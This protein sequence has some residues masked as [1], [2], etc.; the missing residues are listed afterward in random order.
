LGLVW[1]K[2]D[3]T[4][5]SS[6]GW[7]LPSN[8]IATEPATGAN[9]LVVSW[10]TAAQAAAGG[11]PFS[12][13]HQTTPLGTAI[14]ASGT[15]TA[16]AVNS[17]GSATDEI[18]I[19][20][21]ATDSGPVLTEGGTLLWEVEALL[22]DTSHGAQ[23]YAGAASVNAT[24]TTQ[25]ESYGAGGVSIKPAAAGPVTPIMGMIGNLLYIQV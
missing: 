13:A 11:T 15:S 24:W 23:R 4:F 9:N 1:T 10:D 25:N 6:E 21:I 16:P 19:A 18:V 2:D 5:M 17:I 7:S 8:S 22:G 20:G 12:G 14:T 3:A